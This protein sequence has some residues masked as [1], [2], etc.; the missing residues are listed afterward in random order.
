[1]LQA[2][3]AEAHQEKDQLPMALNVTGLGGATD[4]ARLCKAIQPARDDDL[5]GPQSGWGYGTRISSG[6]K[7][8]AAA[9]SNGPTD[10]QWGAPVSAAHVD[11]QG[12]GD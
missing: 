6:K 11:S 5:S 3:C 8:F 2:W 9:P 7:E 1:M 12:S 10:I 4:Y